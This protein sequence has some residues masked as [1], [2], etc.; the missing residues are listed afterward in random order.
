MKTEAGGKNQTRTTTNLRKQGAQR[1]ILARNSELDIIRVLLDHDVV[2]EE[3]SQHV[4]NQSYVGAID[5][6]DVDLI[7][8]ADTQLVALRQGRNARVTY[9]PNLCLR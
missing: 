7:A 8:T 9:S 2:G 6:I 3:C 1:P 4:L 5:Q